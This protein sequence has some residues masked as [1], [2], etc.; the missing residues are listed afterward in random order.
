MDFK[1]LVMQRYSSRAYTGEQI[2]EEKIDQ[3][4][5][6][7]RWAPTG[8]NLQPW[9]VRVV[10]DQDTKTR[11]MGAAW[12]QPQVGACSH[13]LVLCADTGFDGLVKKLQQAMSQGGVPDE[14]RARTSQ[15]A[16]RLVESMP[17]EAR[18]AFAKNQV[19]LALAT[20]LYAAKEL[21]IDSCPMT[22]FDAARVA[23]ILQ[24][25]PSLIPTALCPLGYGAD[26]PT[27]RVRFARSELMF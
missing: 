20:A 3:L 25:P 6:V 2:P 8:L 15:Y 1:D 10:R 24:T 4:L 13:L 16:R 26:G 21:G 14:A 22:G 5:E 27:P 19:Y 17:P 7:M 12:G 18:E 23:E 9:R 11:L